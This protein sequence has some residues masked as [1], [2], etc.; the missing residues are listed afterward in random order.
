[1]P[2]NAFL[3]DAFS[4]S[5]QLVKNCVTKSI[6]RYPESLQ[7]LGFLHFLTIFVKK[8]YLVKALFHIPKTR[9]SGFLTC[10]ITSLS[11]C[12]YI[13]FSF[14]SNGSRGNEDSH[15]A[16]NTLQTLKRLP[17]LH[18]FYA[19]PWA[20]QYFMPNEAAMRPKIEIMHDQEEEEEDGESW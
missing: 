15:H 17:S 11:L 7:K 9:N 13:F 3:E 8:G 20:T 18:H 4:I 12:T 14:S 6:I 19:K 5:V 2:K 16:S 1:M 10:P